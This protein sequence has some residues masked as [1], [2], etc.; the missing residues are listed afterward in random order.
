VA[1]LIIINFKKNPDRL[2]YFKIVNNNYG[3]DIGGD[4]GNNNNIDKDIFD[5]LFFYQV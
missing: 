3:C 2:D 1:L 5:Y 4:N